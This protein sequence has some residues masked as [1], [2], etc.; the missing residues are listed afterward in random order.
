MSRQWLLSAVL[1]ITPCSLVTSQNTIFLS[2]NQSQGQSQSHIPTDGQYVFMKVTD[3]Y[4]LGALS[5]E[6]MDL[7]FVSENQCESMS[8]SEW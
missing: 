4:M 3:L 8:Q 2:Q 7:S 1:L 5:D 6:R